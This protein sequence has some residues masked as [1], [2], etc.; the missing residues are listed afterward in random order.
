MLKVGGCS[1]VEGGTLVTAAG[2]RGGDFIG[3][4][5]TASLCPGS[6]VVISFLAD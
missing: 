3:P 6:E 5:R 4:E 1:E 2:R